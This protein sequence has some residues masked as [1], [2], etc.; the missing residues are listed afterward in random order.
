MIPILAKGMLSTSGD[1]VALIGSSCNDCHSKEF[2]AKTICTKCQSTDV[3]NISL[4]DNGYIWTFTIQRFEPPEPYAPQGDDFQAFAVGYVALPSGVMV[5]SRIDAPDLA[6]IKIGAE[7]RLTTSH[8]KLD[9][10]LYQ[11]PC[12]LVESETSNSENFESNRQD[13]RTAEKVNHTYTYTPTPTDDVI[14]AGIGMHKFGR[15]KEVSALEQGAFAVRDALKDS[16]FGWHDMQF[17]FGGSAD[18]GNPDSLL[19]YL[20]T[21]GLPF[22]NI[23]NGCATGGSILLSAVNAIQSGQYDI[24]LAVGFDKHPRGAFRVS[25]EDWGLDSF[26]GSAG[27]MVTA[28]YF[29]MKIQRYMH[30]FGISNSSLAMVAAKAFE[31]GAKN[32]NAWRRQPL[33]EAE[34]LESNLVVDPLR[35]YML[36][37][38]GE[39]GVALVVCHR[40]HAHRLRNKAVF[41]AGVSVKSRPPGSFDVF[42]TSQT[43][44]WAKGPSGLAADDVF[45]RTGIERKDV[46]VAQLQDT[47]AGAEII[48]MSEC[49][50]CAD[51][52][53]EEW[54]QAGTTKISGHLPINT[55]GGCLANGEPIGASGLRQIYEVCLQ[56]REKAGPRQVAHRPNLGFTHVYGAPGLSAVSLLKV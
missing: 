32:D 34:I 44:G 16:G 55:D 46:K 30:D 12:Y 35:K 19:N 45:F 37:S 24:G 43:T 17:A 40:R 53:Q 29:G 10:E 56:L 13:S 42:N 39:G 36:C 31:N 2:P 52:E 15:H 33:S 28:Q 26:W 41:I 47:E 4:G 6:A 27:M 54:I 51:G 8:F 23:F 1:S 7:V 20:G 38:P 48:H 22:I 21:T 11:I 18:G 49:G 9:D 14:I 5:K 25:P 3:Q 50:F